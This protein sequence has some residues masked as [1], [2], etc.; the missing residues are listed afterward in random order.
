MNRFEPIGRGE[1]QHSGEVEGD[2][3]IMISESVVLGG[4]EDLE[5]RGCGVAAEIGA[6][7]IQFVE[8]YDGITAFDAAECLDDAPGE[9]SDVG[10]AVASNFGL[11]RKSTRLNSSH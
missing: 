4:V 3:E 11:D 9:G 5:Q 2:V 6:Y 1:E 7:F 10:A 8:E